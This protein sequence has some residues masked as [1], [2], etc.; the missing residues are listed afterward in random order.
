[1]IRPLLLTPSLLRDLAETQ[2]KELAIAIIG[3]PPTSPVPI[4]YNPLIIPVRETIQPKPQTTT[5]FVP[6]KY[7]SEAVPQTITRTQQHIAF[8]VK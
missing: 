8:L 5:A 2:G 7:H 4:S 3:L 1:V 6:A